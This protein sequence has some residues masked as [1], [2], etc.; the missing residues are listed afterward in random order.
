M[1]IQDNNEKSCYE[2]LRLRSV[3]GFIYT[4]L[5]GF[6]LYY[7]LRSLP[8][9][10]HSFNY[11]AVIER[12][13]EGNLLYTCIWLLMD[14]TQPQFYGGVLPSI[15]IIA[16]GFIAWKLAVNGSK[17][18]GFEI[19]YGF[20]TMWPWVLSS[21]IISLVV[22]I[23]VLNSTRYFAD[24]EFIFLPTFITV[25][26]APPSLMLMYGPSYR[27]LFVTS[28]LGGL[29]SFP[30][31]F[32]MMRTIV[33]VFEI[34]GVVGNVLTM[35]FTGIII[36]QIL[37]SLPWI[38]KKPIKKARSNEI[39]ISKEDKT[40]QMQK[41]SWFVRRVFADFSEALFYGNEIAGFLVVIGICIEW[42]FNSRTGIHGNLLIPAIVLSQFIGSGV[43][44]L[45]YFSKY[46]ELGWY[47]TYVPLVS[48]GPACVIIFGGSIQ[49]AII[50]GVLGGILGGPI[51]E[52]VSNRLPEHIHG[53]VGNVTSMAL[54]TTIVALIMEVLPWI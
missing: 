41:P 43:G 40:I 31:A 3:L 23:F 33:P 1:G 30:I 51:A 27:T 25:A 36:G 24:G 46:M 49:V 54:S 32:W 35:A 4:M 19:C 2:K 52:Y 45:L 16:G 6:G 11:V 12:A 13:G 28:I 8:S 50:A 39:K 26:G 22:A 9:F 18:S 53:T 7:F 37:K 44:I 48:V 34:P 14:F 42:L 15:G 21:Q 29:I 20:P 5:I 38:Q 17:N 47:A 10:G